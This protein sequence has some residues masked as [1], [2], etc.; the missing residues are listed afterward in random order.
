MGNNKFQEPSTKF[1]SNFQSLNLNIE[2][3]ILFGAWNLVLGI[4]QNIETNLWIIK[5][6]R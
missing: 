4:Y 1:Q 5:I 3:W 2:S 6:I